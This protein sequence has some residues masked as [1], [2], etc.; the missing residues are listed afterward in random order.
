MLT[1]FSFPALSQS[2]FQV[3]EV[4]KAA[5][6]TGGAVML[7]KFI[8]SNL[9]IPIKPASKG[10]NAKVFVK[11][12]VE[13]DGSMSNLEVVRSVDSLSDREAL[14]VMSLYKV[15]KPALVKGNPVRQ[16]AIFP[17]NLRTNPMP[18]YDST[19]NAITEYFDKNN[20]SVTDPEKFKFRNVIP[21]DERGFVRA[22]ILYQEL[23]S[24]KWKTEV[25][26]PFLK[27]EIW[28]PISGSAIMDS[29]KAFRISAKMDNYESPY[30]EIILQADGKLLAQS[31]CPG[32]GRPPAR[33]KFY[34]V[35]GMLREEQVAQDGLVK[36]T[37]WYDNGQLHSVLQ[38]GGGKGTVVSDVWE[39]DGTQIVKAGNGWA[40]IKGNAY[41]GR[42]VM[43]EGKVVNGNRSGRWVGKFADSTL[44]YEEFYNEGKLEKGTSTFDQQTV[45]YGE[46]DITQPQ[47]KGGLNKM[48][49]FL[50][51]NISYPSD[52]SKNRVT[53]KVIVSFVVG[54][55]GG[56]SDYKIEQGVLK[57]L[58]NEAM[59][60]IKKMNGLWEP[61]TQKG[62]K[63]SVRYK[64][65]I[66][67][68][69]N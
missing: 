54:E 47:F 16:A 9:Q 2:V 60:V 27:K 5:E 20:V 35:S 51:A 19:E 41:K 15:W 58:D 22:D 40:K 26:I 67:F 37:N 56:L 4:E 7:N 33:G 23:R 24:G 68:D 38:L 57:S 49:K 13:A 6:P 8:V 59:R 48:Y 50:G 53:G 45:I 32:A 42:N 52:A 29:V 3:N 63:I 64:L 1:F 18:E 21:V 28:V 36:I 69:I 17:V 43:E 11:G 12:I 55:D 39:R 30:E 66:N 31:S 44:V 46:A 14:R 10:M 34:F 25:T 65:P 62:R 61:G